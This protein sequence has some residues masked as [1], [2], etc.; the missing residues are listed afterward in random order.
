MSNVVDI[1]CITTLDLDPDRAF[2]STVD[3]LKDC[4]AY[5]C[6]HPKRW[7]VCGCKSDWH[8]HHD[9]KFGHE[10]QPGPCTCGYREA[11]GE[12]TNG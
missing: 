4:P 9:D 1:G 7:G 12:T 5:K 8:I 11:M 6:I 2:I 3:H 10:F